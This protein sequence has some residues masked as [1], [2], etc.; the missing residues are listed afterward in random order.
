M[1]GSI[2]SQSMCN[3]H[4]ENAGGQLWDYHQVVA[5]CPTP[6]ASGGQVALAD[7]HCSVWG[8]REAFARIFLSTIFVRV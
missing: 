8:R 3:E 1:S 4:M 6:R 5:S 2:H 7:S